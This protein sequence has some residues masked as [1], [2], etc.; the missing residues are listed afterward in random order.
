MREDNLMMDECIQFIIFQ[1]LKISG[2]LDDIMKD[3]RK[4]LR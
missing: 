3:S 2:K 1:D 4:R